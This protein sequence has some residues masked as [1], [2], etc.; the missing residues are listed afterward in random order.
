M[1]FFGLKKKRIDVIVK[2]VLDSK[3]INEDERDVLG[4]LMVDYPTY[5]EKYDDSD[6]IDKMSVR[7][8]GSV[9][10]DRLFHKNYPA[11]MDNMPLA[12]KAR[13]LEK[14]TRVDDTVVVHKRVRAIRDQ[15]SR[16]FLAINNE[17]LSK[18]KF[19]KMLGDFRVIID[20]EQ[21]AYNKMLIGIP[22]KMFIGLVNNDE[23][24]IMSLLSAGNNRVYVRVGGTTDGFEDD[25]IT[26]TSRIYKMLGSKSHTLLNICID[27]TIEEIHAI[28]VSV[29]KQTRDL[30]IRTLLEIQFGSGQF[31]AVSRGM[32]LLFKGGMVVLITKLENENGEEIFTG[33][34]PTTGERDITIEFDAPEEEFINCS[35]CQS[36][37]NIHMCSNCKQVAYCSAECQTIGWKI[38]GHSQVCDLLSIDGKRDRYDE[39]Y[40]EDTRKQHRQTYNTQLSFK[41]QMS[42][43]QFTRKLAES[44]DRNMVFNI[45]PSRS[46]SFLIVI[47]NNNMFWF[48]VYKK[49]VNQREQYDSLTPYKNFALRYK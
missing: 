16:E 40:Q 14:D 6:I 32:T 2:A 33:A 43:P 11:K 20:D 26:V 31:P 19:K 18:C 13:K 42:N 45:I 24:G 44:F 25:V 49:Y 15:H 39:Y 37:E 10:I 47:D 41:E 17:G 36:D 21:L 27:E 46:T 1:K 35:I 29:Y 30:D 34:F 12:M 7:D 22:S 5:Q 9:I 48:Y 3:N 8:M 4:D 23:Y 28:K 38:H